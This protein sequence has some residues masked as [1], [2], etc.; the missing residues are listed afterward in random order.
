MWHVS[1]GWMIVWSYFVTGYLHFQGTKKTV[2]RVSSEKR[3]I[4]NSK[5]GLCVQ[6]VWLY[7]PFSCYTAF[8]PISC[9]IALC[10][11]SLDTNLSWK[12]AASCCS[13]SALAIANT[14]GQSNCANIAGMAATACTVRLLTTAKIL[15][16]SHFH[17]STPNPSTNFPNLSQP[18]LFW[19]EF[20]SWRKRISREKR[21]E[22]GRVMHSSSTTCQRWHDS[23][24]YARPSPFHALAFCRW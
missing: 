5:K 3:L 7:Q 20:C 19:S 12:C 2:K 17:S 13:H 15:V 8:L 14:A 6:A 11:C 18:P 21:R 23:P 10:I 1:F 22:I 24:V 9:S 4:R 16:L